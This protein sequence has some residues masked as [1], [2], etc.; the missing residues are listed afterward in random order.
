DATVPVIAEAGDLRLIAANLLENAVRYN[1]PGGVVRASVR[2]EAAE[3]VLEVVDDGIGIAEV[4]RDRVF[5][6]FYRV[7]K[8]RSRAVGGTGLG[9]SIVRHA[10]ERH[11]GAVTVRSVLGEGSTFRVVLPVEGVPADRR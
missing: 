3:V 2:R 11:G 7:D 4:D 6:R 5:E 1:R 10:A 8:A 9:L